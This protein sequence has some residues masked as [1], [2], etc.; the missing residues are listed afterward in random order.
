MRNLLQKSGRI[1]H[2]IKELIIGTRDEIFAKDSHEFQ[3]K[4]WMQGAGKSLAI[5]PI[6]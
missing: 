2:I 3:K 5:D 1:K 6:K 4:G